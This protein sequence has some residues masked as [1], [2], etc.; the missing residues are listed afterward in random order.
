MPEVTY[1]IEEWAISLLDPSSLGL[2]SSCDLDHRL[3][4]HPRQLTPLYH[5]D[6]DLKARKRD[7]QMR[8]RKETT[9]WPQDSETQS[10]SGGARL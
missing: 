4:I 2:P 7:K 5:L 9:C 3:N 6:S 8:E 10:G 1:L